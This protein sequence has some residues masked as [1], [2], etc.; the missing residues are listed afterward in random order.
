M[1]DTWNKA[2][3]VNRLAEAHGYRRYLEICAAVT[4]Q[5]YAE[6]DR[7]LLSCRRLSYLTPGEHTDGLGTDYRSPD[8]DIGACLAQLA[9]DGFA[10]DIALVDPWHE[11]E[12]SWRDL[13]EAFRLLPEGGSLVVHDCLPP[14][15]EIVAPYY[16]EGLPEWCGV[17]Y[18]AY[19][20]FVHG[21]NDLVFYTVDCDYGCGVIRKKPGTGRRGQR[22]RI[23]VSQRGLRRQ[24]QEAKR[25][26]SAEAFA[27]FQANRVPLLDLIPVEAFLAREPAPPP[28]ARSPLGPRP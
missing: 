28:A 11:Y 17:T 21:R 5:R 22:A 1:S 2:R 12:T 19:V 16:R 27:F 25:A 3:I 15:A 6:I 26:G 14:R 24:W 13:N 23:A 4:G 10:F 9:A 20:D 18:Q 7:Q 8:R